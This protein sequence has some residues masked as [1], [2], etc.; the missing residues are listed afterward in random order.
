V[1]KANP[2][3]V[4]A[5]NRGNLNPVTLYAYTRPVFYAVPISY[6]AHLSLVLEKKDLA[7]HKIAPGPHYLGSTHPGL[8]VLGYFKLILTTAATLMDSVAV[9]ALHCV[10]YLV[11][12]VTLPGKM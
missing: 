5:L 3:C 11:A 1:L 6:S 10:Y 2:L 7:E 9:V 8:H 4:R 12:F